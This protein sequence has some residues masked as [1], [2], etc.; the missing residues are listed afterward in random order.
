VYWPNSQIGSVV[1]SAVRVVIGF[2]I[3]CHGAK[4]F[5]GS[6]PA[7]F[8]SW[9]DWY[10][11]VLELGGGLLLMAG[12]FTR[13][14]AFVLSGVMAFAYFTVHLPHGPLPIANGGEQAATNSWV[15]LL[16][17]VIGAGKYSLDQVIAARR[18]SRPAAAPA[19][20]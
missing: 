12:L 15:F 1:H 9:P 8:G 19:N 2:L 17:V 16:F 20:A 13:V 3:G 7:G 10:A 5:F 4:S 18:G 6:D 11:G 14:A